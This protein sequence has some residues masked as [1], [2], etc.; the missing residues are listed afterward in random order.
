M[1]LSACYVGK[2]QTECIGEAGLSGGVLFFHPNVVVD[3]KAVYAVNFIQISCSNGVIS[4]NITG[5]WCVEGPRGNITSAIPSRP[6]V[7]MV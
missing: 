2:V 6:S 7:Q 4:Q 3:R 1:Y 5:V